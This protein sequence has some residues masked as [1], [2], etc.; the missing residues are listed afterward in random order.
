[1]AANSTRQKAEREIPRVA[2]HR[3][4]PEGNGWVGRAA[5][6]TGDVGS[7]RLASLSPCVP[8]C[9][10][11]AVCVALISE[12]RASDQMQA[13]LK[14]QGGFC[15]LPALAIP[16]QS[17]QPRKRP[18]HSKAEQLLG[19]IVPDYYKK[20]HFNLFP[21]CV[22]AGG[23]DPSFGKVELCWPVSPCL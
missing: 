1:L 22:C 12:G 14:L 4:C 21:G 16:S 11:R 13:Y 23:V 20:S 6:C 8:C 5:A 2:T 3:S 15:A 17:C 19:F 18:W 7:A 10:P 9:L